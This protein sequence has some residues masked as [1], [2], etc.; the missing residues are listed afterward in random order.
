VSAGSAVDQFARDTANTASANTVLI[1]GVNTTQNTNITTA[2]NAAWAAFAKAN[3]ALANT[4]GAIFGG[5]LTV[6]GNL[7]A[8]NIVGT[9]ANT[10]IVAGNFTTTF[11]TYGVITHTGNTS[12]ISNSTGALVITGGVG[13]KGNV[14]TGNLVITG[15]TS[16]GI[17]FADGTRQTTAAV[18]G[19]GTDSWA[20]DRANAAINLAQSA[21]DYANTIPGGGGGS[22]TV[23]N[24]TTSN[25]AKFINFTTTTSGSI[26]TINTSSNNLT[27]VPETGTLK[28][29][30]LNVTAN[31]NISANSAT[32]VGTSQQVLDSFSTEL[33]RGAFYQ[34]QME[35]S[36]GFHVLNISIVNSESSAQV[37]TFG[38]AYNVGVLATFDASVSGGLVQLKITPT[39]SSTTVSYLRH[40][41]IKLTA[42]IPTG[43]LGFVADATTA[44][45]DA[46]FDLD[47]TTS[48]FDYGFVS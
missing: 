37:T 41:L 17:T 34:I 20:R 32:V 8:S 46:G 13:I 40:A 2:N 38:D 12:S 48:T 27:Y 22:L 35:T 45:F 28:T 16:N 15:T 5:D 44:T 31:T 43:D 33:Y 10:T 6:T 18:S 9:L 4:S 42:G 36:A 7:T 26:T 29:L 39:Q 21:Y 23:T 11:D 25:T 3:N 47:A 24:D 30:A 14:Y 1:Q 19:S